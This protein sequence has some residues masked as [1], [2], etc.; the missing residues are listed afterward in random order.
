MIETLLSSNV[1]HTIPK[2]KGKA[3]EVEEVE[4]VTEIDTYLNPSVDLTQQAV[5]YTLNDLLLERAR[6]IPDEPFVGYP[7]SPW[8]AGDYVY[9]TPKDLSRF[10]DGSAR[11]LV[12]QGLPN[13]VSI[14]ERKY[15]PT[16]IVLTIISH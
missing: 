5:V 14:F 16:E 8:S 9:Y 6:T 1:L 13:Y 2:W 10:A 11:C 15:L 3:E 4:E 12:E 7:S